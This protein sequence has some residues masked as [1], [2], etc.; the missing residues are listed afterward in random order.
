ATVRHETP[1]QRVEIG[2]G[3]V[4][5]VGEIVSDLGG[6]MVGIIASD[7][8]WRGPLG[9]RVD[10]SL[11]SVGRVVRNEVEP[12]TPLPTAM[13]LGRA[14]VDAGVDLILALGGGSA[15]D[16]GKATAAVMAS[17]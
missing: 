1:A 9:G 5:G 2:V 11:G 7:R 4:D 13:R 8:V 6:N 10:K 12:H 15:S 16:L 3:V 17:M 14:F